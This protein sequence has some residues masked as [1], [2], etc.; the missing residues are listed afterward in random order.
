MDERLK[1][2]T[3]D[4][5]TSPALCEELTSLIRARVKTGK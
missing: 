5:N 2:E 3:F 1:N 4:P